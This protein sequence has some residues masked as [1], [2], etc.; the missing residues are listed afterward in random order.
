MAAAEPHIELDALFADARRHRMVGLLQA[1]HVG[2]TSDEWKRYAY[3]QAQFTA[4]CAAEAQRLYTELE[5]QLAFLALIK[6]PILGLQAWPGA[7]MRSFDDLDF[8]CGHGDFAALCDGLKRAGYQPKINDVRQCVLRWHYGWG[9]SFVHPDGFTVEANHRHFPPH[10]PWP[11]HLR[12]TDR[13]YYQF[14]QLDSGSVRA[15]IPALH[16]LLSCLHALWHGGERLSWIIDIA[17]LLVRHP[18]A[19]A[20]ADV[21]VRAVGY[22][23]RGLHTA[24]AI[25]DAL[26]GPGLLPHRATD[27]VL[28]AATLYMDQLTRSEIGLVRKAEPLHRLL[29]SPI[30]Q[31]GYTL[32]RTGIP[33]DGDFQWVALPMAL[34]FA[35]WGLRPLR[36]ATIL[37]QRLFRQ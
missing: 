31:M 6:G 3:G 13:A 10:Y 21:W 26:L 29:L 30:E 2:P 27:V 9:A 37:L 23:R 32:R 12:A 4:R 8:R 18:D 11:A 34:R 14:E 24:C 15:P 25:A 22:A 5:P 28:P 36:G 35:Y 19:F 1:A 7:G 17:G 33:G 16:L 20:E